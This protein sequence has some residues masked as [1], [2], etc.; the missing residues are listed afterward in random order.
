MELIKKEPHGEY[1][2]HNFHRYKRYVFRGK[3]IWAIHA[4]TTKE[5]D[6]K[7]GDYITYKII[8]GKEL[9]TIYQNLNNEN[10]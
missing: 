1:F 6:P 9:E 2:H 10:T 4:S 7:I 5:K 3:V 8:D